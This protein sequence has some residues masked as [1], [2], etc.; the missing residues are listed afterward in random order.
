[1]VRRR[2]VWIRIAKSAVVRARQNSILELELMGSSG[3]GIAY[4]KQI[5]MVKLELKFATK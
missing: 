2:C 3:I 5:G 1:M 4:L